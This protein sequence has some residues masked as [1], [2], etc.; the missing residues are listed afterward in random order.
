M[1]ETVA[2]PQGAFERNWHGKSLAGLLDFAREIEASDVHLT[3]GMPPSF[4]VGIE[5]DTKVGEKEYPLLDIKSANRIVEGLLNEYQRRRVASQ[6]EIDLSVRTSRGSYRINIAHQSG[7]LALT[8]RVVPSEIRRLESVGFPN[9]QIIG[10]IKSIEGGLVLV[11]GV[12]G[13]GKS[14][15][16][17]SIIDYINQNDS[18]KIITL[19]DPV[20]YIHHSKKSVVW[21]REIGRDVRNFARGVKYAMR[22]DPDVILVGEIRDAQTARAALSAAYSGHL[23]F[24]TLHT[25]DSAATVGRYVDLFPQ[26]EKGDIASQLSDNLEVV[27]S[28]QLLP[29][30][31]VGRRILAMEAMRVTPA[32]R[33][34]ISEMKP[35]M[36]GQIVSALQTGRKIGSVS[37]DSRLVELAREGKLDQETAVYYAIDRR[38]VASAL[39]YS[40]L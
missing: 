38:S 17:A 20:E 12:T 4:R 5:L 15:T 22:Q 19:E 31:T 36:R 26:N 28:Q 21:Q 16:L 7:S 27:L 25:R 30:R 14:T 29:Y 18:R 34:F 8:A 24:S 32:I 2:Q 1:L 35:N 10:T 40:E 11:T 33:N 9:E 23:V 6:H 3:V 13:S 39:D 37:M